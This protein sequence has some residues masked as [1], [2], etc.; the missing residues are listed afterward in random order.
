M[1]LD[2][3]VYEETEAKFTCTATTDPEEVQNLKIEWKKDGE[4][5]DYQLAQR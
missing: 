2:V 1:P 5:I 4:I 3:M